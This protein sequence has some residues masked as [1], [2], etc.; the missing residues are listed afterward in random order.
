MALTSDQMVL[1]YRNMV[2]ADQFN[3]MMY[4]RMMQG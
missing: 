4:R 1:L 3:K 2:R